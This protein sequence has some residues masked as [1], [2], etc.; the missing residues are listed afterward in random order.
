MFVL[1]N[2]IGAGWIGV[3]DCRQDLG[4]VG[5]VADVL[6]NF[7][8]L[9]LLLCWP[10]V[11][12]DG[13]CDR[14]GG[15][16]GTKRFARDSRAGTVVNKDL[17]VRVPA[18][19]WRSDDLD[20]VSLELG[21]QGTQAGRL[22]VEGP[23]DAGFDGLEMV[24]ALGEA[25]AVLFVQSVLRSP[26]GELGG[27]DRRAGAVPLVVEGDII[28]T[29]VP[30]GLAPGA[31]GFGGDVVA[32]KNGVVFLQVEEMVMLVD[33]GN[34]ALHGFGNRDGRAGNNLWHMVG[35]R[36][37]RGRLASGRDKVEF[38]LDGFT[39]GFGKPVGHAVGIDPGAV[40]TDE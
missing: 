36:A 10:L 3:Q 27:H 25:F 13:C 26:A 37:L 24:S 40:I 30:L 11:A 5:A 21:N 4:E 14:G 2:Y 31:A 12:G 33:A 39:R 34:D 32:A 16:T 28:E 20:T 18:I 23:V 8:L 35:N 29:I 38:L 9:S 19:G 15:V 17:V 1:P 7:H 6:L 22:L